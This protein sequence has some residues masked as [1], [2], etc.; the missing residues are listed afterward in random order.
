MF[1]KATPKSNLQSAISTLE[2]IYHSTVRSVRKTHGNAFFA[3]VN[4][5]LQAVIFV[6]AFY[7]MFSVLGLRG[8]ALR[9]D[10]LLYMMSG[11]FLFLTHIKAL[12]AVVGAEGPS[13]PMMQHAPMN[14]IISIASAALGSLYV[15]VLSL[16]VILFVY[17]VAFNPIEIHM[18]I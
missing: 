17:H 8:A 14:T 3:L 13:S 9:G 11:I 5:I 2:L 1:Q 10:F 18:P 12:G 4:N 15:Q 6:M 7:L 16:V